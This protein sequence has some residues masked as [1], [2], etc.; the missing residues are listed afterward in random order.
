MNTNH[1]VLVV[2]DN[3]ILLLD[4]CDQLIEFGYDPVPTSSAASAARLLDQSISALVTDIELGV[5]PD[6]LALARLAARALPGLPIVVVSGGVYP[7]PSDL[8]PNAV[9]VPKPYSVAHIAAALER[10]AHVEAA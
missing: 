3:P 2:E 4:L 7:K 9:F 6:G 8:A 1:R 5:G 10:N